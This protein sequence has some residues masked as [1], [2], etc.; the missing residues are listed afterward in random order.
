MMLI[1]IILSILVIISN[2]I[3]FAIIP[4]L[5]NYFKNADATPFYALVISEFII[6]LLYLIML[7]SHRFINNH[8]MI[9]EYDNKTHGIFFLCGLFEALSNILL[10]YASDLTRTP[11]IIQ[12]TLLNLTF[13]IMLSLTQYLNNKTEELFDYRTIISFALYIIAVIVPI[14]TLYMSNENIL[15][16]YEN[17]FW[18]LIYV[19]AIFMKVLQY[20]SQRTY[21]KINGSDSSACL[22]WGS[23]NQLIITMFLMWV[24]LIPF[25]GYSLYNNFDDHT[26][27]GIK[28]YFNVI[29]DY[30]IYFGLAFVLCYVFSEMIVLNVEINLLGVNM[31]VM[32]FVMLFFSI[33]FG[34]SFNDGYECPIYISVVSIMC[35]LIGSGGL[36]YWLDDNYNDDD[37]N[38]NDDSY[39]GGKNDNE[40]L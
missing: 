32:I 1:N 18:I 6:T 27:N 25:F 34:A 23:F 38:Y 7:L 8:K 3:K 10:L 4:L 22:F 11:I 15:N 37:Y 40:L 21:K 26:L 5:I 20:I 36:M 33:P 12:T 39:N 16:T 35:I 14:I 31:F 28:C 17:T 30:G 9:V 19:C 2:S 13:P 29:C 24:D